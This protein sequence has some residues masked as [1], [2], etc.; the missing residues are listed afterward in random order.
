MPNFIDNGF[1]SNGMFVGGANGASSASAASSNNLIPGIPDHNPIGERIQDQISQDLG[2][3]GS[4]PLDD[5][6][7]TNINLELVEYLKGLIT[8]QGLENE[9]NRVYNSA[10]AE[11]NR[12]FQSKEAQ[13][14][15]D[16]YESQSNTAYQRA[17]A[18]MRKAGINPILAYQQG[19]ASSSGTGVP[20]GS[21]AG[22]QSTGG[23]T[24]SSLMSSF[25]DLI[26]AIG[27]TATNIAKLF[28]PK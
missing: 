12:E 17:V 8:N 5:D 26:A 25:A 20:S 27:G 21:A 18:D 1:N 10:E 16:W 13:I 23:D 24:T 3:S 6:D 9:R 14:Q 2:I 7:G 19:G 28:M 4:A 22:Y 11:K 15:R